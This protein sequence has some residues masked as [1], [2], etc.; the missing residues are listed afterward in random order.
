MMIVVVLAVLGIFPGVP[1]NTW[2][3]S[4]DE[5]SAATSSPPDVTESVIHSF[6]SRPD[7]NIG[8]CLDGQSPNGLIQGSDGNFY[9]TTGPT[10]IASG[11]TMFKITPSGTLTTLHQFCPQ[12]DP[13]R[14]GCL[15]GAGPGPVIEG[16]GGNFLRRGCRR[17][18]ER[19]SRR[20]L[21]A[22]LPLGMNPGMPVFTTGLSLTRMVIPLAISSMASL[23]RVEISKF[24]SM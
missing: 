14:G 2:Y 13:N 24:C 7:T 18:G 5:A 23:G 15:D 10:G 1:T 20:S 3:G 11:G 19:G 17:R 8:A 16:D 4:T 22:H 21:N 9:G 6:C 12:Q